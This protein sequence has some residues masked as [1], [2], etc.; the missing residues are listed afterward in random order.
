MSKRNLFTAL[1]GLAFSCSAMALPKKIVLVIFENTGYQEALSQPFFAQF[2]KQGALLTNYHAIGHPS[3]P[4]Y[5]AMVSG[6]TAGVRGDSNVNVSDSNIGDLLDAQN[7]TW[8]VYAESFPG[9]CFLGS[10]SG[11]YYRKHNPMISFSSVQNDPARCGRITDANTFTADFKDQNLANFT[12]YIPDI[13]NDGH[14]TGAAA[15]DSFFNQKFGPLLQDPV[16]MKDVLVIAIFDE[17]DR[18]GGNQVYAAIY[19]PD[20]IPGTELTG[21]YDHYSL[22]RMIEDT[23]LL[24]NLGKQDAA[25]TPITGFLK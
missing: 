15:A 7:K 8:H 6:S 2:A 5:V 23:L 14:D 16:A 20:V 3:Q 13:N 9:N 24:P 25:A 17:D 18:F 4:N 12:M 1:I 22:L 10:R 11:T 21:S 19:G